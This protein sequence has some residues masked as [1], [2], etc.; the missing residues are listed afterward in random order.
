M[1]REAFKAWTSEKTRLLD[2]AMGTNLFLRGMPRGVNTEKW[3]SDH[4][5][6]AFKLQREYAD[7]GSEIVYAPTF[8]ANRTRLKDAGLE[9]QVK[10]LNRKLNYWYDDGGAQA[11]SQEE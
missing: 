3:V 8:G 11:P 10:E 4:P 6:V 9:K 2:G 5:G 1:N 7:A